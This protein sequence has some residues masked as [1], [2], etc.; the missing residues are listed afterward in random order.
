MVD[1]VS[2]IV[3]SAKRPCFL[4]LLWHRFAQDWF[5]LGS[6]GLKD[7]GIDQ[8]FARIRY[9]PSN[10]LNEV[11]AQLRSSIRPSWN[12]LPRHSACPCVL[13]CV[14]FLSLNEIFWYFTLSIALILDVQLI[15]DGCEG[16]V[17]SLRFGCVKGPKVRP[18]RSLKL[19]LYVKIVVPFRLQ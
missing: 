15:R 12:F 8:C 11:C 2:N 6:I 13:L 10:Y 3:A 7:P 19:H 16:Y 5:Q 4:N 18:A 9:D 17:S 1:C 14:I